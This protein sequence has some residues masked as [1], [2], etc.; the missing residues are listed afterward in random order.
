MNELMLQ[1]QEAG[2]TKTRRLYHQQPSK[3]PG[4]IRLGRD[5][6]RCDILFHDRSVSGLHVEIYFSP[7]QQQFYLRNL[8]QTN[9]PLIDGQR[10]SAGE[11]AL[12]LG[13][14]I[15]LGKVEAVVDAIQVSGLVRGAYGLRCPNPECGK[16]SPYTHQHL[17]E[18]CPICGFALDAAKSTLITSSLLRKDPEQ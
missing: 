3:H 16:V 10:L 13:T 7:Q 4:T 5:P 1:W 12:R 2:Q 9:P 6:A 18:G 17:Q 8:R 15:R 11:V 14:I